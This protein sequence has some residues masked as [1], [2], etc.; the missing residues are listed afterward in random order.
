[1]IL[2]TTIQIKNPGQDMQ[3]HKYYSFSQRQ[4][5]TTTKQPTVEQIKYRNINNF[6]TTVYS[7]FE[8]VHWDQNWEI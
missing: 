5:T 4:T 7:H 2:N 3:Q 1:M 8:S 6:Q